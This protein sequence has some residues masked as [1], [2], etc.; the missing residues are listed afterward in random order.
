MR[1]LGR[2]VGSGQPAS[3]IVDV[4][5][6]APRNSPCPCG[7]RRVAKACHGSDE[8]SCVAPISPTDCEGPSE[9]ADVRTWAVGQARL[10]AE[11]AVLAPEL[12]AHRAELVAARERYGFAEHL[13]TRAEHHRC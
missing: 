4:F 13:S 5:R 8:I 3:K 12:E 10:L 9:G 1:L 11:V 2:L 6:T 7:S